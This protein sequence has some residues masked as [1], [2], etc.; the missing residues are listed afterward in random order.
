MSRLALFLALA[1]TLLCSPATA[2]WQG[3]EQLIDG[4]THVFNPAEGM[5]PPQTVALEEVWRLGGWDGGEDEFFGV[6]GD[7]M[8]DEN[9]E[10]YVLDSQLSEINVYDESG[11]W[12][13]TI[14]REGE[15]PGEFRRPTGMS[16]MPS[17][18]IGVIQAW[19]SKLVLITPEGDPAGDFRFTPKGE[20]FPGLGGVRAMGDKLGIVY[21]VSQPDQEKGEFRRTLR[22]GVFE[23]SGDEVAEMFSVSSAMQYADQRVVERDWNLFDQAWSAS[24]DGRVFARTDFTEYR[25]GVWN[26][27]GSPDRVIVRDYPALARSDEERETI[28]TRWGAR[29]GRWV[30]DP[31]FDIEKNW[32]PIENLYARDDGS[33]WVRTSRGT[34]AASAGILATF[35]VYDTQG[36]FVREMVLEGDFDPQNDGLF[37]AGGYLIVVTDLVSARDAWMGGAGEE[38]MDG[39]PEP[40]EVVCYRMDSSAVAG[41]LAD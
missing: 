10:F 9:N 39:D 19:P 40:M 14:G 17:G 23:E 35:D 27:D 33:L 38:E 34:R 5:L 22:L 4:V 3:E 1:F 12:L 21:S 8:V 16:R 41:L 18:A 31:N 26:A 36:R 30:R 28:E 6:I 11:A 32:N 25:V 29:L 20:G 2:E 13:R 15:G 37:L 7:V 24:D